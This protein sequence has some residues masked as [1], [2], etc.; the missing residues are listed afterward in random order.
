MADIIRCLCSNSSMVRSR[1]NVLPFPQAPSHLLPL[2]HLSLEELQ[3]HY[4]EALEVVH[5]SCGGDHSPG[6]AGCSNCVQLSSKYMSC[7][8]NCLGPTGKCY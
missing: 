4:M 1:E 6:A 8:W 3:I 2:D 5:Y 7:S